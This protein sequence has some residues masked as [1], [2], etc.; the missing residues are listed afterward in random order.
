M[1]LD[2]DEHKRMASRK[3]RRPSDMIPRLLWY[4][5]DMVRGNSWQCHA[6]SITSP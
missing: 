3:E 5:E 2:D 6:Y 4:S 1:R